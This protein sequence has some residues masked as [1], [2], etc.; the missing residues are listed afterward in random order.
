MF[1]KLL[2]IFLSIL[3]LAACGKKEPEV[4]IP[5]DFKGPTSGPDPAKM[6]PPYPPAEETTDAFTLPEKLEENME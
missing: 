1:K 2:I 4:V 5:A 6:I 3:F